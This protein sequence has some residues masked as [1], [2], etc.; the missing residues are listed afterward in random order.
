MR[1]FCTKCQGGIPVFR[2]SHGAHRQNRRVQQAS[3]HHV[4]YGVSL[5]ARLRF[6]TI[7]DGHLY[8]QALP[9]EF[10]RCKLRHNINNASLWDLT[11]KCQ[12]SFLNSLEM[13]V[14]FFALIV[15]LP[16]LTK[17][18]PHQ[19]RGLRLFKKEKLLA[20]G[21]VVVLAVGTLCLGLAPAVSIAIAGT[22]PS[23]L[24]I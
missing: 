8:L 12:A 6:G 22:L 20:Q 2:K 5:P 9:L 13:G 10:L 11:N 3:G 16:M 17:H 19:V 14:E 15:V 21:S 1:C 4:G 7:D 18:A 24:Y 23:V